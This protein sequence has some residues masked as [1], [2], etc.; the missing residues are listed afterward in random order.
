MKPSRPWQWPYPQT[1]GQVF[2][3]I[4]ALLLGFLAAAYALDYLNHTLP[5]CLASLQALAHTLIGR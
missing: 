4:T 3:D 5:N 2:R 1:W